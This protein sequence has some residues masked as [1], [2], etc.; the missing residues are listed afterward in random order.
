MKNL[1]SAIPE[2]LENEVF[3]DLLKTKAVRIE[4]ILSKGHTS[5]DQGWYD[6]DEDEWVVVLAGSGILSFEDGREVRLEPGDSMNIPAHVKH[7]VAWTDPDQVT[8]WLA[9]FHPATCE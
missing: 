1:F 8:I 3:E 4:R 7:K 6:Q 9:V 2:N 5:P